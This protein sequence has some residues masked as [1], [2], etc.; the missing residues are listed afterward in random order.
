MQ[1]LKGQGIVEHAKTIQEH[2]VCLESGIWG[3]YKI[4]LQRWGKY[5]IELVHFIF[6][7]RDPGCLII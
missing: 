5:S 4:T 2:V 6:L 7:R 1:M 3:V